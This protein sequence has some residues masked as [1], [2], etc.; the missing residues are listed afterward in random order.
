MLIVGL[1]GGIAS[2][3]ST[4][5]AMFKQYGLEVIE[6]DRLA[7][8]VVEKPSPLLRQ[9]AQ[10]FGPG[11]LD[12]EGELRRVYLRNIVFNAPQARMDL[13]RIMHPFIKSRLQTEL[14]AIKTPMVIVDVPLLFEVGWDKCCA[15]VIVVYVTEA[16]QMLRL[17]RRDGLDAIAARA[18][19]RAQMPL[20]KKKELG[21]FVIDN[22]ASMA[23]TLDQVQD[24]WRA[25]QK[26]FAN[27]LK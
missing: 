2:G 14:A 13:N 4:V 1:T 6:T 19:L 9:L 25:L 12:E 20:E 11:V 17:R 27:Q 7:R 23:Q 18:A 8:Q 3:K 5:G 15:A 26:L 24:T 10:R 22:S 16:V 21:Q